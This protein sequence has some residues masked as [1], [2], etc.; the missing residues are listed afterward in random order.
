MKAQQ[1]EQQLRLHAEMI[2][3]RYC[4]VD[5][6]SN[7]LLIKFKINLTNT[8]NPAVLFYPNPYPALLI[9]K[10]KAD[11]L[12]H[13]YE[14]QLHAPDVFT[15]LSDHPLPRPVPRIIRAGEALQSETMEITV[16]T[17]RVPQ[18]SRYEALNIGIHYIQLR[19]HL[20]VEGATSYVQATS[21]PIVVTIER[22]TTSKECR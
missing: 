13:K 14:I 18:V 7:S 15:A 10:T 6:R 17:P 21:Q 1:A 20:D 9:A 12:K 11:L 19:M 2:S 3:E 8:Q 4:K 22:N 16:P 5:S